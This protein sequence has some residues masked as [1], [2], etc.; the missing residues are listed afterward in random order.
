VHAISL[1]HTTIAYIISELTP[2]ESEEL[3]DA[4][5]GISDTTFGR[6]PVS[7]LVFKC[8]KEVINLKGEVIGEYKLEGPAT[9]RTSTAVAVGITQDTH[10][11]ESALE[12]RFRGVDIK[13]VYIPRKEE[14]PQ[15]YMQEAILKNNASVG[16]ILDTGATDIDTIASQIA[17]FVSAAQKD[18]LA[19]LSETVAGLIKAIES[20]KPD[21]ETLS[22][23]KEADLTRDQLVTIVDILESFLAPVTRIDWQRALDESKRVLSQ[24]E[25]RKTAIATSSILETRPDIVKGLSEGL[26]GNRHRNILLITD[27]RV[28]KDSKT[29]YIKEISKLLQERYAIDLNEMF[30]KDKIV[31]FDELEEISGRSVRGENA[32][33][34]S[35]IL[36]KKLIGSG[37]GEIVYVGGEELFVKEV[38]LAALIKG[39]LN[40]NVEAVKKAFEL[41]GKDTKDLRIE[42]LKERVIDLRGYTEELQDYR[43][44]VRE[45]K[46]AL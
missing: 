5:E 6:L 17:P 2:E 7:H 16:I 10:I 9:P 24:T 20:H 33:T 27:S 21:R 15:L 38:D 31:T 40:G 28:T 19:A 18:T 34:A 4:L 44:T 23:I 35:E 22:I 12:E 37:Y 46:R 43:N 11:D 29:K 41:L 25:S 26:K 39:V 8:Y 30:Q 13:V 3:I 14:N 32:L 36:V 42:D 45:L 1:Y